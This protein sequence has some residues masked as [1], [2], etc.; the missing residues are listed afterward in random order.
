M[1]ES[2]PLLDLV[3]PL[4]VE[5]D[6]VAVAAHRLGQ[7]L[8]LVAERFRR[9]AQRIGR[10]VEPD[11][12]GQGAGCAL[13]EVHG[14]GLVLV[15][16]VQG[17]VGLAGQGGQLLGV[18]QAGALL[19]Q[20]FLLAGLQAGGLDLVDLVTEQIDAAGHLA[21]VTAQAGQLAAHGAQVAHQAGDLVAQR[22]QPAVAVQQVDVLADAHQRQV[23]GLAVDVDQALADLFQGL[24]RDGPTVDPAHIAPFEADLAAQKQDARLVALQAVFSQQRADDRLDL[25][26]E[27]EGTLDGRPIGAGTDNVGLTPPAQQQ[28]DG[29]DDDR[30]A[31]A[32]LAGQ[33]VETGAEFEIELVDDGQIV[34][35]QFG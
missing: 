34:N 29:V 4:G 19:R 15:A 31:G 28:A 5:L 30:L 1:D 13:K 27:Q 10:R 23:L 9:L 20:L 14:R 32:G 18:G 26:V 2:Q 33:D 22:P 16:L 35:S 3:Q 7:V 21:L 12:A 8:H 11:Q 6:P 17:V 24:D 25:G